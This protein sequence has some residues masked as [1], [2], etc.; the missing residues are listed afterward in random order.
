MRCS[1]YLLLMHPHLPH[2]AG[3]V[4]LP[5]PAAEPTRT[6]AIASDPSVLA[7]LLASGCVILGKDALSVAPVGRF[8][9]TLCIVSLLHTH[10]IA[11]LSIR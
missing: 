4:T 5:V 11:V 9:S 6:L 3:C 8:W 1:L 10:H 2:P 7:L